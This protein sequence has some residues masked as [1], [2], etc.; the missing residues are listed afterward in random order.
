MTTAHH[1]G[2]PEGV[3]PGQI[4]VGEVAH[5]LLGSSWLCDAAVIMVGSTDIENTVDLGRVGMVH[6]AKD[7]SALI[8]CEGL[9]ASREVCRIDS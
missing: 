8:Q 5:R 7:F 9:S 6:T 1:H 3:G 4:P 2:E